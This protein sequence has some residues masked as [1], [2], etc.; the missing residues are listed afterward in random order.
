VRDTVEKVLDNAKCI[1]LLGSQGDVNHINVSPSAGERRGLVYDSFDGVPRG[2]EHAIHIGRKIAGIAIGIYGKAE[3]F[4]SDKLS[5]DHK[6]ISI[7][8]N[9]DNSKLETA[10]KIK[11]L[12]DLGRAS[13]LPYKDME[14]TTVVAEAVRI[15]ELENGPESFDFVLSALKIGELVFAGLP[16]ECFTEIGKR[17]EKCSPEKH[18]LV[19]CLTN[20][21]D[22]YFPTSSAYD[23]GGYESRTS[24]LKKGGDDII[25]NGMSTLLLK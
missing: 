2:Y 1:F 25:V 15:C 21:G 6:R 7:P 4:V 18:T 13:E 10:K 22:S 5:F 14:L 17:I 16:G 12:Y 19:C 11:E 8:S 20:G 9:Q 23:E 3:P 24:M